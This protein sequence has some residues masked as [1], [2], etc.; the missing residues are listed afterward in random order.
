M[1][2]SLPYCTSL[3][4]RHDLSKPLRMANS[5]RAPR[6]FTISYGKSKILILSRLLSVLSLHRKFIHDH[7]CCPNSAIIFT[8]SKVEAIL[9][10]SRGPQ[11]LATILRGCGRGREI[12]AGWLL[13][14]ALQRGVR[15]GGL[16]AVCT[17]HACSPLSPSSFSLLH[18][19]V[20]VSFHIKKVCREGFIFL[21][22][23]N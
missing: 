15:G 20:E 7:N 18:S 9:D 1:G 10:Y 4:Y 11:K 8:S 16:A 21:P 23:N 19:A 3:L 13:L 5:L 14:I 2:T 12:D 22:C 6:F 17:P